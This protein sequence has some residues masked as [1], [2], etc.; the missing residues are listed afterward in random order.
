MK[1]LCFGEIMMRLTPPNHQKIAQATSLDIQYGGSEANVAVSLAQFGLKSAYT[2]RVPNTDLG[3]AALGELA[4]Y[5]VDTTPS[6]FGGA[7]LGL[8]F[9]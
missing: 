1:I 9:F 2:T 7:R 6:V 5:G 4:K 8:Y 3:R